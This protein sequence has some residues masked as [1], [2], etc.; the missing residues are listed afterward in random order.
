[1]AKMRRQDSGAATLRG[2]VSDQ[3][4]PLSALR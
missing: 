1:L 2:V 3:T 4:R